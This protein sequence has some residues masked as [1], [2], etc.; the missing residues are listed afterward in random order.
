MFKRVIYL[1]LLTAIFSTPVEA[2]EL[3]QYKSDR[4]V[5]LYEPPL[6]NAAKRLASEYPE[7]KAEVEK[8]LEWSVGFIPT[9]VLIRENKEF[10]KK[11]HNKLVTAFA[12]PVENV[13]TIDYS[14]TGRTPFDLR[15]TLEHE[16]CHLVL[17]HYIPDSVPRWL[18]EGVAQ[19][20]SGGISDIIVQ[21][22]KNILKQALLSGSLLT[23]KDIS[24]RFPEEPRE[25]LLSYEES[26]GFVEFIVREYGP[27]KLI[28]VLRSLEKNKSIE[29]A[30]YENLSTGMDELEKKWRE[31]LIKKYSW[32]SYIADHIYGIVFFAAAL[33]TLIGYMMFRRRM[34]NVRD[35][36]N[37]DSFDETEDR[38]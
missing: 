20:A 9:V 12:I 11:A 13:I 27:E 22:D 21:D 26:K 33:A 28:A 30:A 16:I 32:P 5:I 1:F 10:Q 7:I 35:D 6:E 4:I 25:L 17:H 31:G 8:K 36:D 24:L 19:W 18:D 37:G 15:A 14:K 29:Q 3:K 38:S 23:L 34:R 2:S